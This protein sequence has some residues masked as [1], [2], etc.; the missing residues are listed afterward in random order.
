MN[1]EKQEDP[2]V[3]NCGYVSMTCF[4]FFS[5]QKVPNKVAWPEY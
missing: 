1:F 3:L 2:R 4:F 5:Y